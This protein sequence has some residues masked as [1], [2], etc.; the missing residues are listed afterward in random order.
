MEGTEG[1]RNLKGEFFPKTWVQVLLEKCDYSDANG[2]TTEGAAP[3]AS[4]SR[5]NSQLLSPVTEQ[6]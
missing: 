6:T 5:G 1:R 4:L 3:E 2:F